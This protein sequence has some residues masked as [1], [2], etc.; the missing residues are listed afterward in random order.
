MR[1]LFR[2]HEWL[3][4]RFSWVQYPKPQVRSLSGH[5]YGWPGKMADQAANES[6]AGALPADA[7]AVRA[8]CRRT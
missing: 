4:D 8:T 6:R 7:H 3:A 2:L 5:A 1:P